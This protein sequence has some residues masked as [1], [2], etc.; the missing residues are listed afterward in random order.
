MLVSI[1]VYVGFI[2][3][4]K[5]GL[6]YRYI[7]FYMYQGVQNRFDCTRHVECEVV[8]FHCTQLCTNNVFLLDGSVG[9]AKCTVFPILF[10]LNKCVFFHGF[11]DWRINPC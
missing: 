10:F 8:T 9:S 5:R 2:F 4:Q 7:Y 3:S 1:L 6:E 11:R